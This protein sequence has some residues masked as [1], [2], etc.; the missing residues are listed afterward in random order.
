LRPAA[1]DFFTAPPHHDFFRYVEEFASSD[2]GKR[3]A[4]ASASVQPHDFSQDVHHSQQMGGSVISIP[5]SSQ[6]QVS[7]LIQEMP[8]VENRVKRERMWDL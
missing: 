5:L 3:S 6:L 4:I 2:L 8:G 7:S 1:H